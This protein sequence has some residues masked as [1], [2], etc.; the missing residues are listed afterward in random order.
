MIIKIEAEILLFTERLSKLR[1]EKKK[2]HQEMANMLGITRQ[3]YGYYE[4]GKRE[5]DHST[6]QRLANFFD[7]ST[8]Y[9]LGRTD[10]V[11]ESKAEYNIAFHGGGDDWT[12]EE[13]EMARAAAEKAAREA[14]ELHRYR[15]EKNKK[16]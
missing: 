16:D 8:D 9:L 10:S 15:K 1:T 4:S 14:V 3:A 2:T 12:E 13:K 5:T 6:L 7:V 11:N